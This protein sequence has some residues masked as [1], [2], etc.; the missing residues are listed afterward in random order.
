MRSKRRH[1]PRIL[2]AFIL[3]VSSGGVLA[4]SKPALEPVRPFRDAGPYC[5][6]ISS[7]ALGEYCKELAFDPQ[8]TAAARQLL[9]GYQTAFRDASAKASREFR[10]ADPAD[11]AQRAQA[12]TRAMDAF[13]AQ[14][15]T[16]ELGLL[17]DLRTLCNPDQA[18]RFVEV[19]R[20]RRREL[21][22]LFSLASGEDVD[23]RAILKSLKI[24]ATGQVGEALA[25]WEIDV[26]R[27]ESEKEKVYHDAISGLSG[28]DDGPAK[29][30][31]MGKHLSAAYAV[32]A[33]IRDV[34]RRAAREIA[35][36]L[37]DE[38][39]AA[40]TREVQLR[41]FPRV[42]GR[43]EVTRQ[44]DAALRLADLAADQRTQLEEARS[45]YEHEAAPINARLA[46]AMEERQ[47]DFAA[48]FL[49][50]LALPPSG[51]L[52]AGAEA[53]RKALDERFTAK[54]NKVLT[55]EQRERMPKAEEHND[56]GP[57]FLPDI[58]SK[59]RSGLEEWNADN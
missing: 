29:V 52:F 37:P 18:E 31:E 54:I 33:H 36:L 46:S 23:L 19:Q 27:L 57:A 25:R 21:G 48:R 22:S 34:N 5:L 50:A 20:M 38:P 24:G 32:S 49:D 28:I 26:D 14:A 59:V 3:L 16:L 15:R 47:A 41:S 42:Y 4:Q 1:S 35:S 17:D 6:P 9:G 40:L 56:H 39:K 43:S 58:E 12:R 45:A 2:A 55:S 44:L 10:A 53:D 51:D 30:T 7:R 8:Q 11:A 13:V